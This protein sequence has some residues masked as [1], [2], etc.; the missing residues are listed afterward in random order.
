MVYGDY[1]HE[2]ETESTTMPLLFDFRYTNLTQD[3]KLTLA[4]EVFLDDQYQTTCT[5]DALASVKREWKSGSILN[6]ANTLEFAFPE[7][8]KDAELT[9]NVEYLTMTE[10][11][12]LQYVP[13][14]LSEDGLQ[15]T[16]DKED[17]NHRLVLA[18][19]QKFTQPGTYRL[20]I[21][22]SYNG[23]CY[24]TTQIN[25]FVN[26]SGRV[27]PDTSGSEVSNDE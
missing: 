17:N 1:I 11:Q 19:G 7:E 3:E 20:Q 24:D 8:W 15:A 27:V 4:M 12:L 23:L 2:L 22:W 26:C 13:V 9:Y 18:L 14:E 21:S 25:F 6:F 10:E 16:Y 5:A